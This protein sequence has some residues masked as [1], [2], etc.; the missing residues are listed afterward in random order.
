[1]GVWSDDV[2][3]GINRWSRFP[4][5]LFRGPSPFLFNFIFSLSHLFPGRFFS[6]FMLGK[7]SSQN[8]FLH[9]F[10]YSLFFF[11]KF[12]KC[13]F[14]EQLWRLAV[15]LRGGRGLL[16]DALSTTSQHA[17]PPHPDGTFAPTG[18]PA[19]AR[20]WHRSPCFMLALALAAVHSTDSRHVA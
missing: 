14:L 10:F 7:E 13:I 11:L 19:L 9:N 17:R 6:H 1:M 5:R 20:H 16:P 4:V 3:L 8:Y 15:K 12:V 2:M 18:T